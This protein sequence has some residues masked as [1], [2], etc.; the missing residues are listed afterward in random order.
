MTAP[1]K[2]SDATEFI[3]GITFKPDEL[4]SPEDEDAVV[5]MRT[6]NVQEELDESDLIAVPKRL[7]RNPDKYLRPGDILISSANSWELVGKCSYVGEL[8]YLAT[9]GGFISIVRPKPKT[10]ARFLYHWLTSPSMQHV[11]R[12]LGRQTTNISN[13]DVNRFKQLD[14]PEM[15]FDQQC[16][17]AA[18]LDKAD[19]I[20]RKR[21]NTRTL[22]DDLLKSAYIH[23]VGYKN[24]DYSTWMPMRIEQ[25]AEDRKGAM[26]TGPFG[27]AL[28]HSEFVDDGVAVLGID[29]AVQNR[30]AWGERRFITE[31]KYAELKRY[32]VLPR[33]VII[34]IMGTTGRSAVVP[35]DIAEAITT[36]HLATIT[37]DR[38]KVLPEF[39]S[40]VIHSDPMVIRQI[41][42]ANKGA[43]MDGLN[44]SIIR[45]LEINV[46]PIPTQEKFVSVLHTLTRMKDQA[47]SNIGSGENLLASLSQ[48]AF[49]GEL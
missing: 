1:Q 23:T 21:E 44:L 26:R 43:I 27:S 16:R 20:R 37:C 34:T 10:H 4:I 12:N 15:D 48:R 31:E 11:I 39:L 24:P 46:P 22:A 42:K 32:R 17:I 7:V 6:K 28:L 18:I 5:C 40:F 13:L 36:K 3:R 29:N 47:E 9:A 14:F 45:Q 41:Q 30:F 33:D 49:R 25:M 8:D 38:D 2:I 19:A 35:D